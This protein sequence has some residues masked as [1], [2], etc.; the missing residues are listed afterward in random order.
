MN[1]RLKKL[2]MTLHGGGLA[3]VLSSIGVAWTLVYQPL[4]SARGEA[5]ARCA[6]INELLESADRLRR[7][8]AQLKRLLA[9]ARD[10]ERRLLARV[11]DEAHEADFLSQ[12]SHLAKE[13]GMELR[14]YRPGQVQ[15]QPT[16]SAMEVALT[17]EGPYESLC[18]F[19]DG[20]S[21]LPRLVNLS[22]LEIDGSHGGNAYAA[23]LKLVI[24]F[25]ATANSSAPERKEP[26]G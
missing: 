25:G 19:L 11:P 12:M 7:E 5:L 24:Y 1:D 9:D 23:T 3:L 17:C 18:R 22:H 26:H 10:E 8:Q 4:E 6:E 13:V 15:P 16:C 14:D 20:V 2:D 21:R